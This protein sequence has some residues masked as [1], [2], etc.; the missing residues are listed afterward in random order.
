MR[1]MQ[2][3]TLYTKRSATKFYKTNRNFTKKIRIRVFGKQTSKEK[4]IRRFFYQTKIL[5]KNIGFKDFKKK[6]T[7]TFKLLV[8]SYQAVL[9][10]K[11][12]S[13]RVFIKRVTIVT[14]IHVNNNEYSERFRKIKRKLF[15]NIALWSVKIFGITNS[16]EW[17]FIKWLI[18]HIIETERIKKKQQLDS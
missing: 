10:K 16:V 7:D 13:M 1:K 18:R 17:C 3:T 6:T 8:I 4:T 2:R 12:I 5:L 9:R 14:P 11:H 15:K